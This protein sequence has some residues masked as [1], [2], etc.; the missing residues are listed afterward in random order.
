MKFIQNY[1][2]EIFNSTVG[3]I[4]L[5]LDQ[6]SR[7]QSCVDLQSQKT[8]YKIGQP[9]LI[10]ASIEFV[11]NNSDLPDRKGSLMQEYKKEH[12]GLFT[13]KYKLLYGKETNEVF[14]YALGYRDD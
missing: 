9:E 7:I 2:G 6:K 13:Y 3:C 10:L 8:S 5:Q 12:D 4:K 1:L 11:S 14:Q